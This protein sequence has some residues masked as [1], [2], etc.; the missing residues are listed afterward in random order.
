MQCITR[1]RRNSL[2]PSY[3]IQLVIMQEGL[4][5]YKH[6][7][8]KWARKGEIKTKRYCQSASN[9]AVPQTHH[10]DKTPSLKNM[11]NEGSRFLN[12]RLHADDMARFAPLCS[13][14]INFE[15]FP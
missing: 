4:S 7:P 14:L 8:K 2:F 13:S 1:K 12:G 11:E 15:C 6:N 5:S 10:Y 3:A 9:S